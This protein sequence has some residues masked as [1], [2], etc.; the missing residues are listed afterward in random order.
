MY[1]K[2]KEEFIFPTGT[3]LPFARKVF[4]T[5]NK[6]IL[7]C[8]RIGHQFALGKIGDDVIDLDFEAI[9]QKYN[10]YYAKMERVCDKCHN[11]KACIQCMFNLADIDEDKVPKC[12][13]FMDKIFLKCI[14]MHNI[15][16][17]P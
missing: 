15:F 13:G 9:A 6:K 11:K 14:K 10:T 5:V 4:I 17:C 12:L 16:F 7:P 3:C 1:G 8:E 2:T